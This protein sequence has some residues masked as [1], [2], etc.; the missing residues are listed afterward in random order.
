MIDDIYQKIIIQ[1]K[2]YKSTKKNSCMGV[3]NI[4]YGMVYIE[5]LL[6]IHQFFNSYKFC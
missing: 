6:F 1:K 2:G 5:N 3:D 4:R